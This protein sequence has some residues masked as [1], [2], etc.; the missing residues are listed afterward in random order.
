M[1]NRILKISI[2][3]MFY[4]LIGIVFFGNQEAM[5]IAFSSF[6]AFIYHYLIDSSN[7]LK[8][9]FIETSGGILVLFLITAFFKETDRILVVKY[10]SLILFL[11]SMVFLL[12]KKYVS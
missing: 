7:S 11:F 1:K 2:I 4:I 3:P 5:M 8:A 9:N 6:I 10:I 12:K